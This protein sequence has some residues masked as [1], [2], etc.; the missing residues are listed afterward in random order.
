MCVVD[1]RNRV[2]ETARALDERPGVIAVDAHPPG[3]GPSPRWS[4]ECLLQTG[5]VPSAVL[6][7][8]G[9]ADLELRDSLPVGPHWRFVA[10][11]E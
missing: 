10:A 4:L 3:V 8:L 2:R 6:T 5:G 9:A 1:E 7:E 11:P